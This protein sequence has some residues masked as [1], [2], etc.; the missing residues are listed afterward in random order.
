MELQHG[1]A[2]PTDA[3]PG[4]LKQARGLGEGLTCV[5]G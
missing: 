2:E 4:G 1:G 3:K 5:P